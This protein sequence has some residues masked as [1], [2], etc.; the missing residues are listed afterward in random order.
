[1]S[2]GVDPCLG[3]LSCRRLCRGFLART[4][5]FARITRLAGLVSLRFRR[6]VTILIFVLPTISTRGMAATRIITILMNVATS[7]IRCRV[8]GF[9]SIRVPD[10]IAAHCCRCRRIDTSLGW[11]LCRGRCR[12]R[13]AFAV[14]AVFVVIT[15][16]TFA[17]GIAF[18]SMF[19][20]TISTNRFD[21]TAS[22]G[23]SWGRCRIRLAFA[24]DTVFVRIAI[25]TFSVGITLLSRFSNAVS[26]NRFDPT[27]SRRWSRLLGMLWTWRRDST[28]IITWRSTTSARRRMRRIRAS[29]RILSIVT[30]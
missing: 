19:N 28:T 8:A 30:S 15:I 16:A 22:R 4:V 1:M 14:V 6:Q 24:V 26:T 2:R 3:W 21:P 7:R 18:L 5:W 29:S 10:S 20:N 9:T 12:D 17:V 13:L 25:S 23:W 27:D 11:L